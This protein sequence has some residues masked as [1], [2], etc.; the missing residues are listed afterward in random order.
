MEKT[1][2]ATGATSMSVQSQNFGSAYKIPGDVVNKATEDLPDDQRSAIRKLHAYCMDNGLSLGELEEISGIDRT[3]ITQVFRGLYKAKLDNT[4]D[5]INKFLA[6]QE[7]RSATKKLDFIPTKL[8][9]SIWGVCANALDFQRIAFI[10]GD[11]QIG[12]SVALKKYQQDHNHGETI[13]VEV[14]TG[15]SLLYFLAKLADAVRISSSLPLQDL[16][17]RL[18]DCFDDRMLL[19]VDEAHRAIPQDGYVSSRSI[20][21]LEFIREIFDATGCGLVI[22][23]TNVFRDELDKGR[24]SALLAQ[25]KRRRLCTLQLP[26]SPEKADL[27]TFARAHGLPPAT[28]RY[29][30]VQ[31]EVIANEALGMWLTL[32]RMASKIAAVNEE[33]LDWEHVLDARAALSKLEGKQPKGKN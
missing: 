25:T 19:I 17:R 27:D 20:Q 21:T 24:V 12:K 10:F 13:Y 3:R 15:G 7:R 18:V 11:S 32:L 14:P 8:S 4:V 5:E 30:D 23:A 2:T 9:K 6:M 1:Q 28:G 22:C 33:R 31:T 29:L 16:R 26:D